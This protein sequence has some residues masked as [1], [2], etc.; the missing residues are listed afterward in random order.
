MPAFA[1][2][3][4]SLDLLR[5]EGLLRT[6]DPDGFSIEELSVHPF[7][8]SHNGGVT[9]GFVLEAEGKKVFLATDLGCVTEATIEEMRDSDIVVLESNHDVAMEKRSGRS[10]ETIE[11][12]LSNWGHLSNDQAASA[13]DHA[14]RTLKRI[15]SAVILA[16]LSK[17][18]NTE[19]LA[20]STTERAVRARGL[21]I[22][23][24]VS[25]PRKRSVWVWA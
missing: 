2:E 12:N 20:L 1:A 16:H 11:R 14:L 21:D 4:Q 17:E 13:I 22:P 24:H 3:C 19:E 18:C 5:E 25:Y 15:P 23:V 10:E 6:F 9:V 8:V 7:P